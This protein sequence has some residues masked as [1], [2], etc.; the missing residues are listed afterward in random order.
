MFYAQA[1][2]IA[3]LKRIVSMTATDSCIIIY[4]IYNK[5]FA[6]NLPAPLTA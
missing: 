4:N 3:Y 6:N 5:E 2:L 1:F